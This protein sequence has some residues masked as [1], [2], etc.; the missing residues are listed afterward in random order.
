MLIEPRKTQN[1]SYKYLNMHNI[2]DDSQNKTTIGINDID[3][4]ES[5]Y[6]HVV[7]FY[8]LIVRLLT[9][10]RSTDNVSTCQA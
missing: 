5:W 4:E 2:D 10:L 1:L 8:F 3:I 7:F 9:I 6:S